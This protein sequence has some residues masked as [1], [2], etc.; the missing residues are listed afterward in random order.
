MIASRAVAVSRA[1][2]KEK[3]QRAS[4]PL[5]LARTCNESHMHQF[6]DTIQFA[7]N[8]ISIADTTYDDYGLE[9]PR[10]DYSARS[11]DSNYLL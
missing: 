7:S 4:S 10:D 1:S 2:E 11:R 5:Q 9:L 3:V 6:D 8:V